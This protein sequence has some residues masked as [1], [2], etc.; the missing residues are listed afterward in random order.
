[1]ADGTIKRPGERPLLQQCQ[2]CADRG[3]LHHACCFLNGVFDPGNWCCGA[4]DLLEPHAAVVEGD[5]VIAM[6]IEMPDGS[7]VVMTR[8]VGEPQR[9]RTA[10]VVTPKFQ[11][12]PLRLEHVEAILGQ[13]RSFHGKE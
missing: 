10:L 6:V 11:V 4:L 3:S 12:L 8:R 9:V 1:M 2:W 7:M 5:E 13:P